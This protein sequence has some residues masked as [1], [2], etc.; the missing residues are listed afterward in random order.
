MHL[1]LAAQRNAVR[2]FSCSER[3]AVLEPP[4][5]LLDRLIY[6]DSRLRF[7]EKQVGGNI[8]LLEDPTALADGV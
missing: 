5:Q 8:A 4:T 1:T 3:H 7:V 6:L 2:L